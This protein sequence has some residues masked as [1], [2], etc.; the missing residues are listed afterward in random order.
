[1]SELWPALGTAFQQSVPFLCALLVLAGVAFFF[2]R[3]CLVSLPRKGSLEWVALQER[4]P[5]S[6]TLPCHPMTRR[7]VLPLLLLTAVY[8][9]TAFFRLGS[10]AAPQSALDFGE[11]QTVTIPLSQTIYLTELRY[12]SNL[13]TGSYHVEGSADGE[14]WYGK[15]KMGTPWITGPPPTA[16]LP[17]LLCPKHTTISSSG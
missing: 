2:A 6:L 8:A 1:M 5:F 11:G 15:T 7:D 4:R 14:T 16:M 9:A 3:C 10:F 12:F 17:A 13:G